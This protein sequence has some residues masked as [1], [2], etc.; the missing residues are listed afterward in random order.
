MTTPQIS[1]IALVLSVIFNM[2]VGYIW[3]HP[4]IF[5]TTWM[6]LLKK[7]MDQVQNPGPLYITTI[8]SAFI[9]AYAIGFVVKLTNTHGA[10]DGAVLG[11][12]L[13]VGFVATTHGVNHLFSG[14]PKALYFIDTGYHFVTFILIGA[15]MAVFG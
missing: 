5:G 10:I 14:K 1:I 13:W 2:I 11:G 9:T 3:Y 15:V 7:K 4:A 8:V 12:L 6:K